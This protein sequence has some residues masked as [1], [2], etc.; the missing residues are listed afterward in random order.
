MKNLAKILVAMAVLMAV[1]FLALPTAAQQ[2]EGPKNCM[3]ARAG[4][5]AAAAEP[6]HTPY[7]P[8][9]VETITGEVTEVLLRAGR[10]NATGLHLM[11]AV[12][13]ATREVAVGPTFYLFPEGLDVVKGDTVTVTGSL[14]TKTEGGKMLLARH[15]VA[16]DVELTLRDEA[17]IPAWRG[18]NPEGPGQAT[19]DG[20]GPGMGRGPGMGKGHSRTIRGPIRMQRRQNG[21]SR[22]GL[23]STQTFALGARSQEDN[24]FAL[25][26]GSTLFVFGLE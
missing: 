1:I 26:G 22:C 24:V 5:M 21:G 12:G 14:V 6:H 10:M 9:S 8:A 13:E 3:H 2:G 25:S 18:L 7:D 4:A 15:I 17:G 11:L 23:I 19:A 20:T 16:G